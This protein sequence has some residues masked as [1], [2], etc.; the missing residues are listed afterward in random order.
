M[1]SHQPSIPHFLPPDAAKP[2]VTPYQF[3]HI[4]VSDA[5]VVGTVAATQLSAEDFSASKEPKQCLMAAQDRNFIRPSANDLLALKTFSDSFARHHEVTEIRN[6][7]LTSFHAKHMGERRLEFYGDAEPSET[8]CNLASL[9]EEVETGAEGC[10]TSAVHQSTNSTALVMPAEKI[11]TASTVKAKAVMNNCKVSK[12]KAWLAVCQL[13]LIWQYV[14]NLEAFHKCGRGITSTICKPSI[15]ALSCVW[16]CVSCGLT[17]TVPHTFSLTLVHM[18]SCFLGSLNTG[19][20]WVKRGQP[21]AAS[22]VMLGVEHTAAAIC[23][24]FQQLGHAA[25]WLESAWPG[26]FSVGPLVLFSFAHMVYVYIVWEPYLWQTVSQIVPWFCGNL[27]NLTLP[28]MESCLS[29]LASALV[30]VWERVLWPVMSM[31][32]H[33]GM[34]VLATSALD[35]AVQVYPALVPCFGSKMHVWSACISSNTRLMRFLSDE[36]CSVE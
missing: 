34:I 10:K 18:F 7:A 8:T 13:N 5:A 33:F 2:P 22:C 11:A 27:L 14:S 1:L 32:A 4:A 36:M 25:L 15:A 23:C 29:W 24:L 9:A 19:A 26:F 3:P 28:Y 16:T 21:V 17:V 12:L 20:S 6:E 30:L 31:L 35:T